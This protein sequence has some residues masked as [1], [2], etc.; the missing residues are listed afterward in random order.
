[1]SFFVGGNSSGHGH[2]N[3][4]SSHK[5][6]SYNGGRPGYARSTSSGFFS[7][8][9]SSSFYKRRP[10]DGYISYLVAKLKRL[11][12]DLWYYAQ[13]HPVKAFFAIVVPLFSAGGAIHG[14]LKQF[15]VRLPAAF[16]GT[17][18]T[19]R[20]DYYGSSGYGSEFGRGDAMGAMGAM[21]SLFTIAKAFM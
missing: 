3:R 2:G 18:R 17:S 4:S 13:K 1:M 14:L 16:D 20:G 7:R 15:G 12:A 5:G 8:G 21:G 10:R 6:G 19:Y 11:I 9:G